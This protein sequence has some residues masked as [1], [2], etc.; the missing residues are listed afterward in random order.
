MT[1]SSYIDTSVVNS[2]TGKLDGFG[3]LVPVDN[4]TSDVLCDLAKAASASAPEVL[5]TCTSVV[6]E[7]LD[8]DLRSH[9]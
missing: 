8:A 7:K 4:L 3:F 5:Q 6:L 1:N 2:R 9:L